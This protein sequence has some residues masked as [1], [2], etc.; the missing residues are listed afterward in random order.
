[1]GWARDQVGGQAGRMVG[2]RQQARGSRCRGTLISSFPVSGACRQPPPPPQ[3]QQVPNFSSAG[4]V[5]RR[6]RQSLGVGPPE[7]K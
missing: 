3:Q 1:M 5:G 7:Q 6:Q 4:G 2:R